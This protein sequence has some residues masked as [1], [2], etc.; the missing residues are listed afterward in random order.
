M[1]DEDMDMLEWLVRKIVPIP[2]AYYWDTGRDD[3]PLRIRAWHRAVWG[4]GALVRLV[5]RA[6]EPIVNAAGMRDSRFGFATS[7]MTEEE[8]ERSR[9]A[10]AERKLRNEANRTAVRVEE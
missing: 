1:D 9:N 3:L 5:E 2:K 4:L 7:T 10:V 8:W 6:G